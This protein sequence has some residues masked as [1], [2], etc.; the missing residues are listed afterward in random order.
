[1]PVELATAVADLA[2]LVDAARCPGDLVAER[3]AQVGPQV[4][5][6]ELAHA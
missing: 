1:V 3:I 2:E 4:T 5:L 6:T